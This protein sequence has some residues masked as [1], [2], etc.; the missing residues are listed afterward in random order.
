MYVCFSRRYSTKLEQLELGFCACLA[1][2]ALSAL[3]PSLR[4]LNLLGSERVGDSLLRDLM[5]RLPPSGDLPKL[6]PSGGSTIFPP[7]GAMPKFPPS[8]VLCDISFVVDVR[9]GEAAGS[10]ALD[11]L[12]SAYHREQVVALLL[13]YYSNTLLLYDFTLLLFN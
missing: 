7:R 13:Y 10:G 5:T 2:P 1:D 11:A 9:S 12:L 3:P 4:Y 8:G 6:P